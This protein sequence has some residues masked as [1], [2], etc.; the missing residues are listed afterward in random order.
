MRDGLKQSYRG[1]TILNLALASGVTMLVLFFLVIKI[2]VFN[3]ALMNFSNYLD[4]FRPDLVDRFTTLFITIICIVIFVVVFLLLQNS[5]VAYVKKI[6]AVMNEISKGNLDAEVP[7]EGGDELAYLASTLNNMADDI[8]TLIAKERATE[9]SKNELITN[10]AHDLRTPLTAILGYLDLIE[11]NPELDPET[12]QK[13]VSIASAKAKQL[14]QLIEDLFG[15]TKLSY[16]KLALDIERVDIVKLLEQVID[17]FYPV[18]EQHDM[19]CEFKS[20]I[21]SLMMNGDGTLL[22]RL[23]DNLLNNAAK[24]GSDGKLVMVELEFTEPVI[25]INVTNFGP[26][27]PQNEIPLLFEKFYRVE[28]SRSSSTGGTGLGLA[29]VKSIAELHGG[30]VGCTSE[31]GHTT[32]TV[33]LPVDLDINREHFKMFD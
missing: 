21:K 3:Q 31:N 5:Q 17:E 33:K 6:A 30:E 25:T 11:N 19:E 4:V 27:I 15:F 8:Q 14:Q 7:V 1:T 29:I 24:Y 28:Q 32:F 16:G 2:D 9:A 20:E 22:A 26:E 23:F 18:F 10:V 13:Y 12:R